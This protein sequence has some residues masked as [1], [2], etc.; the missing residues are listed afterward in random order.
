[1]MWVQM[2]WGLLMMIVLTFQNSTWIQIHTN[3]ILPI[4][5]QNLYQTVYWFDFLRVF[6][7]LKSL[8]TSSSAG[9]SLFVPQEMLCKASKLQNAGHLVAQLRNLFGIAVPW[10]EF[11]T[12]SWVEVAM[13]AT[14]NSEVSNHRDFFVL[15][16][17]REFSSGFSWGFIGKWLHTVF[18]GDWSD[19]EIY[20]PQGT[21]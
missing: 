10:S 6:K 14:L 9:A 12:E 7:I 20:P 16:K 3:T 21:N 17:Y 11:P 8:Y 19:W 2:T 15:K 5:G 13:T 4:L 18:K 1:M